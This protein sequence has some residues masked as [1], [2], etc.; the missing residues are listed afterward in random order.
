VQFSPSFRG[1]A[2]AS[3]PESRDKVCKK[4]SRDSGS[5]RIARRPE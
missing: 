4:Q 3:N 2:K 5:A 1:D